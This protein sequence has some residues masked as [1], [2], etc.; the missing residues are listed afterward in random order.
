V[1]KKFYRG[2]PQGRQNTEHRW[3]QGES[4]RVDFRKVQERGFQSGRGGS[5]FGGEQKAVMRSTGRKKKKKKTYK[6]ESFT[7]DSQKKK[8]KNREG[9]AHHREKKT[10]KE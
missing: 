7:Q 1:S 8:G 2:Y 10:T 5:L 9:G 3:P 4:E 6:K